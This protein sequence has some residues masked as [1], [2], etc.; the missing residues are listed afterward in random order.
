M[1]RTLRLILILLVS[2]GPAMGQVAIATTPAGHA[3]TAWLDAFNSGDRAKIDAFLKTY[4][5]KAAES[6]LTS[7]Q[8]RGRSGGVD[9]VAITRSE[10]LVIAFQVLEKTQPTVLLVG[11]LELTTQEPLTIANFTLHP[12]PTGAV[13]EDIKLDPTERNLAIE[14]VIENLN[15]FY[16]Y[17][18]TAQ[19]MADSLH[20]H[21]KKGDYNAISDG[22]EF[23]ARLS[24]DLIDV[25]HDKHLRVFYY[26]YKLGTD[27]P[28]PLT[29]DQ[30]TEYRKDLARDCGF[31]KLEILPNNIGYVKL[32]FFAS[33]TACAKTA[34]AAIYFLANTDAVIFDL[35]ENS[36]GEPSMVAMMCTY[37]FD[38]PT[39]LN[40][41]YDR[42]G[43]TTTEYWTLRYVPGVRLGNNKP[44]YVLTSKQTFSGGEEFAYDLKNL[45]RA[46]VVGETTAGGSHPVGPHRAGDHFVVFVPSSLILNPVTR[47]DWEG[48]GVTPDVPVKAEDAL[49]TA[50]RLAAARIQQDASHDTGPARLP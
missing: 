2:A 32:D 50:E 39:L 24:T 8:F 30:L 29:Y 33:P 45:K 15:Q 23:A 49:D 31:H 19:K 21:E 17:P 6:A 9:L 11:K 43:N 7:P 46:T 28:P 36:G 41:F 4:S 38:Q 37:L 40:D 27:P 25:S 47:G 44:A 42:R 1:V 14:N 22:E 18:A 5:P 35:R 48:T 26:P 16:V 34:A 20:D 12:I 10:R 3:L 13:L